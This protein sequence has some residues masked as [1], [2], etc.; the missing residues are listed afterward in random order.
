MSEDTSLTLL[1][2]IR[3]YVRAASHASVRASLETALPDA[4]SRL[5]YQMCDG[6]ASVEQIRIAA[7]MSPNKLIALTQK[8]VAMGLMEITGDKKRRRLF[9]LGD[10][11]L[12]GTEE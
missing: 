1:T 8:W 3:N 5:T 4:Q 7:K 11:G 6:A 12:L 9:D 2:E 10:F